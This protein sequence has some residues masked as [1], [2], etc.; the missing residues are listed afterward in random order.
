M[1]RA[2]DTAAPSPIA[3]P[4]PIRR[5][6]SPIT[7]RSTRPGSAP[8]AVRIPI[9][10]RRQVTLYAITPYSSIIA[11]SSASPPKNPES[12]ASSRSLAS[13]SST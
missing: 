11:R 8:S 7:I 9:S 3:R 12:V 1:K 6:T 10:F 13:D 4:M 5:A 2:V